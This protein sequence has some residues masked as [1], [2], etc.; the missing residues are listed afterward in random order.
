[1]Q[2]VFLLK[3]TDSDNLQ[4]SLDNLAPQTPNYRL[5]KKALAK[6][7]D[8]DASEI[9]W[10]RIPELPLLRPGDFHPLIP[11]IRKRIAQAYETHGNITYKVSAS[12][13]N[14]NN[15]HYDSHL[16]NA[17]KAFQL[18]HGLNADGVIGKNTLKALN[19]TP[20]E[21]IQQLRINMERLRWLPRELGYR[22]LLVNIAGFQLA[23]IE[24]D[25]Y[26]LDMRIYRRP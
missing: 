7:R 18:Q 26:V 10:Q 23:A 14:N 25:Q 12:E 15:V 24:N 3:S 16:V 19:K 20:L 22:H 9:T 17:I 13:E 6:Y 1:M 5:L 4:R 8:L 21:K 11:L 2:S